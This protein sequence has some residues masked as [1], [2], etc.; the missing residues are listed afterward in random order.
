ML[1]LCQQY[2]GDTPKLS[3]GAG[4]FIQM[5]EPCCIEKSHLHSRSVRAFTTHGAE[6]SNPD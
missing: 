3:C 6:K 4:M 2:E 1:D 5:Q